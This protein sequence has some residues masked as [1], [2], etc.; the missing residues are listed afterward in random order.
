M[1]LQQ[2]KIGNDDNDIT[3]VH[4]LSS[5]Y[6]RLRR[7]QEAS[8]L[9]QNAVSRKNVQSHSKDRQQVTSSYCNHKISL[10][11]AN[12]IAS[13]VKD[14]SSAESFSCAAARMHFLWSSPPESRSKSETGFSL[15]CVDKILYTLEDA[16]EGTS[17]TNWEVRR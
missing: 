7:I 3:F 1:L 5:F 6:K 8:F 10:E 15:A 16:P 14:A 17:L 13:V 11:F 4:D 2:S 12:F 9:H